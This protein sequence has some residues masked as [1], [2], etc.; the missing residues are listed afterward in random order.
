MFSFLDKVKGPGQ[1]PTPPSEQAGTTFLNPMILSITRQTL[2]YCVTYANWHWVVAGRRQ[3][4][5]GV[6]GVAEM[7]AAWSFPLTCVGH[8]LFTNS[9]EKGIS[10]PASPPF[11]PQSGTSEG[12]LEKQ[13]PRRDVHEGGVTRFASS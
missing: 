1:T 8:G 5:S 6:E 13:E 10:P 2:D 12:T 4:S 11:V 3:L 9:R 7:G